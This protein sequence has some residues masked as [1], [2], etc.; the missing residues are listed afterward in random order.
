MAVLSDDPRQ[1]AAQAQKD[2]RALEAAK[3]FQAS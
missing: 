2:A 1:A 3:M